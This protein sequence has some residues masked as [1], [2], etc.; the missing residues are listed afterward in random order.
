MQKKENKKENLISKYKLPIAFSLL[1]LILFIALLIATEVRYVNKLP[2]LTYGHI[3]WTTNSEDIIYTRESISPEINVIGEN[4]D[5]AI[6]I[7]DKYLDSC[8]VSGI[9]QVRI[10]HGKGTGKLRDVIHNYLKNNKYVKSFSIAP[11]GEGDF[12]VTIVYLK[13]SCPNKIVVFF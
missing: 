4:G 3:T 7:I 1:I 6:E 5:S 12:G 13:W 2:W 11:Y 10:V 9:H 8:Y